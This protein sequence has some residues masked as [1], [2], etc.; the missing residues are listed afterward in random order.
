MAL[1][2]GCVHMCQVMSTV[3]CSGRSGAP[4]CQSPVGL[5]LVEPG[6]LVHLIVTHDG[7]IIETIREQALYQETMYYSTTAQYLF[8]PGGDTMR[9]ALASG[10]IKLSVLA[11]AVTSDS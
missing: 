10:S 11:G 7:L 5:E 6:E 2:R 3:K 8:L 9:R 1:I 4:L